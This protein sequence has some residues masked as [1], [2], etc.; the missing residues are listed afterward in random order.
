MATTRSTNRPHIA[1]TLRQLLDLTDKDKDKDKGKSFESIC[2]E[3]MK[4]YEYK[5]HIA[6][7]YPLV[8]RNLLHYAERGRIY[9]RYHSEGICLQ[10]RWKVTENNGY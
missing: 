4:S 9:H 5:E 8:N 3:L 2:T 1:A 6:W 7:H 10:K